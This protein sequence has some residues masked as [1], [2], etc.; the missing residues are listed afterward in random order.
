LIDTHSYTRPNH[1]SFCPAHIRWFAPLSSH[2]SPLPPGPHTTLTTPSCVCTDVEVVDVDPTYIFRF[3]TPPDAGESRV[4]RSQHSAAA[5]SR[6]VPAQRCGGESREEGGGKVLAMILPADPGLGTWQAIAL[7]RWMG[8][9]WGGSAGDGERCWDVAACTPAPTPLSH[10]L[11]PCSHPAALACRPL[12][13]H[14]PPSLV[15]LMSSLLTQGA[16]CCLLTSI[17]G[18]GGGG[19]QAQGRGEG[20][21]H[22]H[23]RC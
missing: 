2:P 21:R 20:G 18:E 15:S 3:P 7:L 1:L 6:E 9:G 19:S 23:G 5:E 16:L 17:S 22:L 4:Q 8:Q 12:P 11:T 10:Q 14:L 13:Q